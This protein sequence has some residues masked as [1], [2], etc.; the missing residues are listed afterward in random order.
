MQGLED[1]CFRFA[2]DEQGR[3][4]SKIGARAIRQRG[5]PQLRERKVWR[6]LPW[7]IPCGHTWIGLKI[8]LTHF[9]QFE[10]FSIRVAF[11]YLPFQ[12]MFERLTRT[13]SKMHI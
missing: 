13:K 3:T 11:C 1:H 7:E 6:A 4:G 9:Y 10:W 12:M 8:Y 2:G 5:G